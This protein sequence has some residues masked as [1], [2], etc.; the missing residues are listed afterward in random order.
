ME[1]TKHTMD[2]AGITAVVTM[3][4]SGWEHWLPALLTSIWFAI[5]IC[6]TKTVQGWIGRWKNEP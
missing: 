3:F 2:L 1:Q 5:R 4:L 6:E